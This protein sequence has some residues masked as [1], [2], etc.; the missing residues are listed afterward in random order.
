MEPNHPPKESKRWPTNWSATLRTIAEDR[1]RWTPEK[2]FFARYSWFL[3]LFSRRGYLDSFCC[4]EI[5]RR[6]LPMPLYYNGKNS[7]I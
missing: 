3:V 2:I 4:K 6:R 7:Y 5:M 1:R